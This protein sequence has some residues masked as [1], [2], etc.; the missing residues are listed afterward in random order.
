MLIFHAVHTQYYETT[1]D[2]STNIFSMMSF[3]G[4][5]SFAYKIINLFINHFH[6]DFFY[7]FYFN[8]HICLNGNMARE[9]YIYSMSPDKYF[10]I[11]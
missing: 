8:V 3:K 7:I 9:I 10:N 5:F 6:S 1:W 2:E 11:G 4:W